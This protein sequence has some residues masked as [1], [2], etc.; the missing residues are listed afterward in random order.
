MNASGASAGTSRRTSRDSLGKNQRR[1]MT[2]KPHIPMSRTTGSKCA[3]IGV[4]D[5]TLCPRLERVNHERPLP[6]SASP[7]V[8][9]HSDASNV[10]CK[11]VC[12]ETGSHFF[13]LFASQPFRLTSPSPTEANRAARRGSSASRETAP[14]DG[15][16]STSSDGRVTSTVQNRPTLHASPQYPFALKAGWE[17]INSLVPASS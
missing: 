16:I 10:S 4:L 1:D 12:I 2:H 15:R 11:D 13:L 7:G 6:A 5:R 3:R 14:P 8:D 17:L 9:T